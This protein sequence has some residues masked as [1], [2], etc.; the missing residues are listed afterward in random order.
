MRY[1]IS[2]VILICINGCSKLFLGS[3]IA[4]TPENNF[5]YTWNT[6]NERYSLFQ[7]DNINWDSVYSVY[8][9]YIN[10]SLT[11]LEQFKLLG[12]LLNSL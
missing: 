10:P 3:D 11:D 9:P 5:E 12:N 2:I 7:F 6:I 8:A 4:N 1:F